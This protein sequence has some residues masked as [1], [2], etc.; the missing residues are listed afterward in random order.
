MP[1]PSLWHEEGLDWLKGGSSWYLHTG[2]RNMYGQM[3]VALS[4]ACLDVGATEDPV[5]TDP[6]RI[7]SIRCQLWKRCLKCS[8][9]RIQKY[10]D[11]KVFGST[12]SR[13]N[14]TRI[15]TLLDPDWIG[16]A[17]VWTGSKTLF[18]GAFSWKY[19][20]AKSSRKFR[21]KLT[22]CLNLTWC[23]IYKHIEKT[24]MFRAHCASRCIHSYNLLMR[25]AYI[26]NLLVF[27]NLPGCHQFSISISS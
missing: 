16:S 4:F 27:K 21:R 14:A 18:F 17:L 20:M 9:M 10:T 23:I 2:L 15:R 11:P 6:A 22:Y 1:I 19:G 24:T 25:N 26:C 13:V 5:Y 12:S 7:G 3:A 8:E